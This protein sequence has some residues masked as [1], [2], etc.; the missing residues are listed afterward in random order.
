MVYDQS[1]KQLNMASP[2]DIKGPF[3]EYTFVYTYLLVTGARERYG[4]ILHKSLYH[5]FSIKPSLI[6]C[7][8]RVFFASSFQ[9]AFI[10]AQPSC[11]WK[12]EV[13]HAVSV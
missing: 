4:I 3:F 11:F 13:K 1:N 10:A 2:F 7:N 5:C 12:V 8:F 6:F 9:N